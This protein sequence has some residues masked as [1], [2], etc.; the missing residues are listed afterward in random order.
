MIEAIDLTKRYEDG[1]LALDHLNLKVEPGEVYCL[2]GANGAGKTTAINLFLNFIEPTSGTAKIKDIDVTKNPLEAKKFVSYVSENVMLYGNFTARQNLDFFTRLGGRKDMN[3]EAYYAVMRRVGLQE[4]AFEQRLKNFSKGMRQKLGIAIAITKN[5]PAI[6][7]DEP[8]SGLDP[9][10]GSEFMGLLR[11]LREED[12]A[13]LMSTHDIFRAKDI[14][15]RVAIM[16][17]GNLVMSRTREELEHENLETLYL[18]Y[19]QT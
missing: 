16:K 12:K 7:L 8:T 10:A 5:A 15:D 1:L 18:E 19:M 13:I 9:K 14:A 11:S 3:K 2:L 6:L 4:K 17:E